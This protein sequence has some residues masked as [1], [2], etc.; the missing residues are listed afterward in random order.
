MSFRRGIRDGSFLN[1]L[2][3]LAQQDG[4]WKDVLADKSLIIGIR[5]EYLNV[6]WQGQSIFKVT[7]KGGKVAAST[8]EKY[9]FNPD[10][11]DQISLVGGS[12]DLD[13]V[14]EKMLTRKYEGPTTLG[15]LKKAAALYSGP[16]KEGVHEIATSDPS[17]V[18]IE[19]AINAAG[20]AN[21]LKKTPRMD[22]ASLQT[23]E[24]G[25]DLVFWEAKIFSNPELEAGDIVDQIKGYQAVIDANHA[26]FAESYWWVAKNLVKIKDW[27]NGARNVSPATNHA[28]DGARINV[29][30]STIGLLVYDFTADQRDR[31][32]KDGKTL[33]EK[34]TESFEKSGLGTERFRFRGTAKGLAL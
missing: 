33:R 4:W 6:Y 11:K 32:G 27:S 13:Q 5:N 1:A 28:A 31:R 17:V 26:D 22:M 9:L 14:T 30:N 3:A 20:V 2:E 12:F 29:R 24:N 34:L 8:H 16:E 23:A 21:V 15:R 7:F 10:L 25:V 19:I 18:D